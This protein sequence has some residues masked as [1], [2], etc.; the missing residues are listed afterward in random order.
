MKLN[1][2]TLS[3][4]ILILLISCSVIIFQNKNKIMKNDILQY[5]NK[6]F[7]LTKSKTIENFE[8]HGLLN[9]QLLDKYKKEDIENKL[10]IKDISVDKTKNPYKI[11]ILG[12]NL[13]KIEKV[14]FDS[15]EGNIINKDDKTKITILPP[16][17]RDSKFEAL[18]KSDDIISLE[19]Q[20]FVTDKENDKKKI[21]EN[22]IELTE[23]D[24][25][26]NRPIN[27][28]NLGISI[29]DIQKGYSKRLKITFDIDYYIKNE[30]VKPHP[31]GLRVDKEQL[32][33]E[34]A[35]FILNENRKQYTCE[36]NPLPLTPIPSPTPS[37]SCSSKKDFPSIEIIINGIPIKVNQGKN[38]IIFT[39][40][41]SN[42][43]KIF[44][45]HL[46]IYLFI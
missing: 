15:I 30:Y 27:Y 10:L 25:D 7:T 37:D 31:S 23:T 33:R 13:D 19:I 11:L 29:S 24:K 32:E 36:V 26:G 40:D 8:S 46:I 44:Q 9:Q 43:K 28:S 20:L 22:A 5:N 1:Y 16:N 18:I 41:K 17:L 42:Y 12:E 39:L 2:I 6:L 21:V 3:I 14:M 35:M 4:L 45:K 38:E 34:E